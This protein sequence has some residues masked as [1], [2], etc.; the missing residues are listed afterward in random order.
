MNKQFLLVVACLVFGF[1]IECVAHT[2]PVVIVYVGP[3]E[4]SEL[5]AQG[6]REEFFTNLQ[7]SHPQSS[8][9]LASCFE[10]DTPDYEDFCRIADCVDLEGCITLC[11]SEGDIAIEIGQFQAIIRPNGVVNFGFTIP[12]THEEC[13]TFLGILA[14]KINLSVSTSLNK[15]PPLIGRAV[16]KTSS[17]VPVF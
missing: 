4:L 11:K 6:K 2:A 13:K 3:D 10:D 9:L 16:S 8:F 15:K 1:K 5:N 17:F 7:Q 14:F 12:V